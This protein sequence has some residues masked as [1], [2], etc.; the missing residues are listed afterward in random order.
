MRVV[1]MCVLYVC[2]IL[3]VCCGYSR[4]SMHSRLR[5][6]VPKCA[7]MTRSRMCKNAGLHGSTYVHV[8]AHMDS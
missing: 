8:D 5:M 7:C 4:V 2:A 1:N 3:P 6:H